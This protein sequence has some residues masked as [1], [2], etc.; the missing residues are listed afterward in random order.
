[1]STSARRFAR[2]LWLALPLVVVVALAQPAYA[3]PR[4]DNPGRGL[5]RP[6]ADQPAPGWLSTGASDAPGS[7]PKRSRNARAARSAVASLIP[8]RGSLAGATV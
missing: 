5:G 3:A 6:A 7:K 4:D 8:V 1:M 2:S